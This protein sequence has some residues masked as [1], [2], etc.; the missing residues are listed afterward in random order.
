M[1]RPAVVIEEMPPPSIEGT[2]ASVIRLTPEL[3]EHMRSRFVLRHYIE[4]EAE[5]GR[6]IQAINDIVTMRLT[7]IDD[8]REHDHTIR[9]PLPVLC[10]P[11]CDVEVRPV[12]HGWFDVVRVF[13][14]GSDD[15]GP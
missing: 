5:R 9:F 3:R 13:C 12:E 8:A 10:Y 1:T 4:D 11:I 14:L 15:T 6:L 7:M 2:G